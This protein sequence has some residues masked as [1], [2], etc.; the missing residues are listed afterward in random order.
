MLAG[1]GAQ[2]VE[3]ALY[4]VVLPFLDLCLAYQISEFAFVTT[5][6]LLVWQLRET[7]TPIRWAR[8]GLIL[9][10]QVFWQR[11]L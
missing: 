9:E 4:T 2:L 6:C 5:T 1:C 11:H 7:V 8:V 10:G 3:V